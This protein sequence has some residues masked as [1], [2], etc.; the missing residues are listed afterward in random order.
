MTAHAPASGRHVS[1]VP[2]TAGHARQPS[3][4]G[5][6]TIHP[7]R[8][9]LAR[10]RNW[11]RPMV[12]RYQ[13]RLARTMRSRTEE[14]RAAHL[15][16]CARHGPDQP[17]LPPVD[18]GVAGG[19]PHASRPEAWAVTTAARSATPAAAQDQGRP[20]P[21]WADRSLHHLA[22]RCR[23]TR[24]VLGGVTPVRTSLT[25]AIQR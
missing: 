20:R 6:P 12:F 10:C 7:G 19:K 18:P 22:T 1:A 8:P 9:S 11:S 15:A 2:T 5:T 23:S 3:A 17:G 13:H 21:V 16:A 24:I 4:A 14:P 25:S